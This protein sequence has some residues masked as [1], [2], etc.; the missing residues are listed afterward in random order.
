MAHEFII[1]LDSKL[2]TYTKYEDIPSVFDNL[3]KFLP[4]IPDDPHTHNQHD[5]ID[6]WNE[7][8]KELL[9][10]ETNGH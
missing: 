4:E 10:R 2:T 8:L 5:E 6:L 9:N 3:I 1:L 7:K